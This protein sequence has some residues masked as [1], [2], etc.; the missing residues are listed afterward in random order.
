MEEHPEVTLATSEEDLAFTKF[1]NFHALQLYGI[2]F[3]PA[4]ERK[5]FD[6]LKGEIFDIGFKVKIMVDHEEE[7]VDL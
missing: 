4:L 1:K 2:Q 7:K 3:P 6:K 5:L